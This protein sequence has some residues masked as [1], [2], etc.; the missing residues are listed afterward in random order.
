MIGPELWQDRLRPFK[1]EMQQR[2]E[3]WTWTSGGC[4]A[5]ASA[6]QA[7]FGGEFYGVCRVWEEDGEID[8]PVDHALVL[9]NGVYYDHS[10]PFDVT[11]I[12]PAQVIKHREDD[13]VGWFEDDFF[14][15]RQWKEIHAILQDC[16]LEMNSPQLR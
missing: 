2:N 8:Y 3:A 14:D 16:S 15:D 5:F 6:F 10:G 9:L 12:L 13:L 11:K 1:I 7:A 4:F